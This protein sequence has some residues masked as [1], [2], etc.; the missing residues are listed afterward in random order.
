MGAAATVGGQFAET[1]FPGTFAQGRQTR[2]V[3]GNP[4]LDSLLDRLGIDFLGRVTGL[5]LNAAFTWPVMRLDRHPAHGLYKVADQ[6]P[7]R[8]H[9]CVE[10]TTLLID[11]DDGHAESYRQVDEMNDP[12]G[13]LNDS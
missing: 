8:M 3:V 5:E 2:Q 11:P 13:I 10:P 4:L 1:D 6:M 12:L 7:G 9:P